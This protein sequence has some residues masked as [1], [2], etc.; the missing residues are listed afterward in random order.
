M[1]LHCYKYS[2]GRVEVA[3]G[4]THDCANMTVLLIRMMIRIMIRVMMTMMM[5]QASLICGQFSK[6][7]NNNNKNSPGAYSEN[8]RVQKRRR[9]TFCDKNGIFWNFVERNGIVLHINS[10]IGPLEPQ[11]A[12]LEP[13]EVPAET[14]A[15]AVE[16]VTAPVD[17]GFSP[18]EASEDLS[19]S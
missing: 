17:K 15:A 4:A 6:R 18:S 1:S 8:C 14:K 10:K 13:Q 19:F 9:L 7:E 5:G 3:D 12:A 2:C 16:Y 11:T